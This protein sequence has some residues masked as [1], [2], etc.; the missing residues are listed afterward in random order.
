MDLTPAIK[1]H[2]E[3]KMQSVERV[4]VGIDPCDLAV[5]IG[6]T[7]NRHNKGKVFVA[8]FMLTVPGTVLRAEAIEE[9][10]YVAI[11]VASESLKRQVKKY[12]DKG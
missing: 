6:R 3:K 10:L 1:A 11:D 12:K 7:S 9:D 4:A 5:D 8:E 2:V